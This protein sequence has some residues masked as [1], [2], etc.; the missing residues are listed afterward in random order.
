MSRN[1]ALLPHCSG[2]TP[3]MGDRCGVQ[4]TAQNLAD[5]LQSRQLPQKDETP[6]DYA[7]GARMGH[8]V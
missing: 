7:L 3:S 6:L 4:T 5:I 2:G 8:F 1:L